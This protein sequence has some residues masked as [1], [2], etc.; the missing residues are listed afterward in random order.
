MLWEAAWAAPTALGKLPVPGNST[1]L[2]HLLL[3][4]SSCKS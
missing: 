2:L 4:G 1:L 3:L